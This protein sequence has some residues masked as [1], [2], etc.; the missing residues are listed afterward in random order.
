MTVRIGALKP[1]RSINR[2]AVLD[3]EPEDWRSLPEFFTSLW[4]FSR[5]QMTRPV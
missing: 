2:M 5:Q 3:I 4:G 1:V